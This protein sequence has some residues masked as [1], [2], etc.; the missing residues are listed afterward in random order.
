[1]GM[2][3]KSTKRLG[4]IIRS[5][6]KEFNLHPCDINNGN[7]DTFAEKVQDECEKEGITVTVHDIDA[8]WGGH[9]YIKYEN[10]C[11]D[12]EEPNGVT[13]FT[14]LPIY[15]RARRLKKLLTQHL[16]FQ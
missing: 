6:V 4:E 8:W 11:Y 16:T 12:A 1:M 3:K 2:K 15:V 13:N 9:V 5:V 10:M 14:Q 7:C